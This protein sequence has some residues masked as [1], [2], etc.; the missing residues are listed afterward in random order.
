[1]TDSRLASGT[2]RIADIVSSIEIPE[3]TIIVN[4]QGDE[5]LISRDPL[6]CL[7]NAF[8]DSGVRMASLMT[9]IGDPSDIQNPNCVKVVVDRF[10]DALYFSRSKIPFDRD[11]SAEYPYMR[12]IGVYA[13]QK[14]TL[15]QFV[16]LPESLLEQAE[17]LEQLRA[18]EN[19]IKIRMVNSNYQG[20]GI[21]TPDDLVRVEAMLSSQGGIR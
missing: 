9:H 13:Y 17:K 14:A 8:N 2:D 18:L 10:Y 19:G 7:L 11:G 4:V 1:M 6:L 15:L 20:I 12:H 16:T 5:P 3:H 21:D